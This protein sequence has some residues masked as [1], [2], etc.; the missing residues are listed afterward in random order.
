MHTQVQKY[1][2]LEINHSDQSTNGDV[3]GI[4]EHSFVLK[5]LLDTPQLLGPLGNH[6]GERFYWHRTRVHH[7]RWTDVSHLLNPLSRVF[8]SRLGSWVNHVSSRVVIIRQ[9]QINAT[10]FP[11]RSPRTHARGA[12]GHIWGCVFRQTRRFDR[13]DSALASG[14]QH[15]VQLVYQMA[16]VGAAGAVR[17]IVRVSTL[18]S[19]VPL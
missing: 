3:L 2:R 14:D 1:I 19:V 15:A 16:V 10:W 5:S 6:A 12:G 11:R 7:S 13:C 18:L 8:T 17:R 4:F 9:R